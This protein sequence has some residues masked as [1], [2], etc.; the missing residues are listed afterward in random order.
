MN[1]FKLIAA[2]G[3]ETCIRYRIIPKKGI[4]HLEDAQVK[5]LAPGYLY[6]QIADVLPLGPTFD[7]VAQVAEEGDVL[8]DCTIRWP[9]S[10]KIVTLGTISLDKVKDD[11][12]AEQKKI[13]FDPVPRVQGIEP[14]DDPLIDVRA[15]LY[16]ISGRERRAA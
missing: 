11:N 5:D 15:A 9:D 1:A 16:L 7:L 12:A 8:D 6:D 13:I 4:S 14:S 2:D 10:R 3:S